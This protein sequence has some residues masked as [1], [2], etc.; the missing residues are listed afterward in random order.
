MFA[1]GEFTTILSRCYRIE[2]SRL[3]SITGKGI[4]VTMVIVG[5][6]G[7]SACT[8]ARLETPVLAATES[9]HNAPDEPELGAA[10]E[11]LG[12]EN[13]PCALAALA[14]LRNT[15]VAKTSAYLELK[16]EALALEHRQAE[17][18]T[19]IQ[20]AIQADPS[21]P[22]S[23]IT[24]GRIYLRF[25]NATDAIESFLKAAKLEPQSPDPL[26]FLG[27]TFFLLAEH[28][29]SSD[30]YGRAERHFQLALQVSPDYHRAE[31]MLGVID[32]MQSR[33]DEARTHLQQAIR[34]DPGNPYYHLHYGILLKQEVDNRDALIE[35]KT[36]QKLNPSYALTH[37]E[38]GTVYQRLED[39]GSAKSELEEA[40]ALNP[41]LSVAYYHLGHVYSRLG[42]PNQSRAAIEKY[43]LTKALQDKENLDPAASAIYSQ[44]SK[45]SQENSSP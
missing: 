38:L 45:D 4:F 39:Y 2:L 9:G 23:L 27:T 19:T 41:N 1:V 16:A 17:A 30:Y 28:T 44:E 24:Q 40:V 8:A 15:A 42:L 22:H 11:C 37:Y 43:K 18:L 21:Q 31:F 25:D 10:Q 34:L 12:H 36:S 32:A 20:S 33:L 14:S 3:A 7:I 6:Q 13:G 35:M 29:Q 26:Y 5:V